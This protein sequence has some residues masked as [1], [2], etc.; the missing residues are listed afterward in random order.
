MTDDPRISIVLLTHN[1]PL[2]LERTLRHLSALPERPHLIVVDNASTPGVVNAITGKFEGI[3]VVRSDRNLGA[4]G[5]N[6][7]VAKVRTRYV[8]FCDD[9]TWWA[10]GSLALACDLMDRH[11]G[12]GALSARVLVGDRQEEDPTCQRMANSPLHGH[13]LPGPALIAF[14]AGAVVMLVDAFVGAGGYEPRL[15]LGAEEALLALDM[16][17]QGWQMAYVADM[18]LHHHPSPQR[19]NRA[20]RIAVARNRLW[21]AVMRLPWTGVWLHTRAVLRESRAGGFLLPFLKEALSGLPWA[22]A[23]RK[24]V[25]AKVYLMHHQVFCAGLEPATPTSRQALNRLA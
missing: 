12:V 25:P 18:V 13:N 16:A 22:I 24:V 15:F 17:A 8:A 11:A 20:R 1:R 19:D 4:A 7:G 3:D 14:M 23:R 10:P 2:E 21:I 5:R 6:L 9:D